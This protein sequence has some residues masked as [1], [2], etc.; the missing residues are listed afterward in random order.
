MTVLKE[1]A[2]DAKRME[3]LQD[4]MENMKNLLVS[5]SIPTENNNKK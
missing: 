4:L 3:G 1:T 5:E 2:A